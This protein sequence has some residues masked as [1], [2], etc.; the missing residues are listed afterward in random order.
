MA[1]STAPSGQGSSAPNSVESIFESM[2]YGPN[3]EAPSAAQVRKNCLLQSHIFVLALGLY[4]SPVPTC[5][6]TL[7]YFVLCKGIS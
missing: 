3:P 1:A 4:V 7:Q 2:E 6:S 5:G